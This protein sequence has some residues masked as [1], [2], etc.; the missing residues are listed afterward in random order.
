MP[1]KR[2]AS[3]SVQPPLKVIKMEDDTQDFSSESGNGKYS[4]AEQPSYPMFTNNEVRF[5]CTCFMNYTY[6]KLVYS[7]NVTSLCFTA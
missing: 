2:D 5:E 4:I 7:F 1:P 6:E 3:A